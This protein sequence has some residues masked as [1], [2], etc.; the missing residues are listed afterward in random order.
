M[1]I[2]YIV[3]LVLLG[4][5]FLVAEML[6]LPGVTLGAILSMA[7]YGGAIYIGFAD[8]GTTVGVI[9]VG[10]VALISLVTAILSLRAKTWRR[11]SLNQQIDSVSVDDPQSEVNIGD[12]G[13]AV[14]R[15]APMGKVNIAGKSYEAKSADVFIDQREAVE[16]IGFE[17][18]AVVVRKVEA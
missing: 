15:I 6:F 3:I 5:L 17:N 18:S 1:D 12:K 16:V 9:V 7:C 14:S 13:V 11:L 8:F 2:F 4:S 10:V